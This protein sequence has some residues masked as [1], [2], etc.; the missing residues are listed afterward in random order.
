MG[1]LDDFKAIIVFYLSGVKKVGYL[2]KNW[3]KVD[4]LFMQLAI[5]AIE[6]IV[7]VLC[8]QHLTS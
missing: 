8:T 4:Y 1:C 7:K 2:S 5:E 3:I 6:I